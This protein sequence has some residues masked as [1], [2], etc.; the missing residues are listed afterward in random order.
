M[1]SFNFIAPVAGVLLAAWLLDEVITVSVV[2]GVALV[3][4]GLL[5]IARK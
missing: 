3:A 4:V 1:L 5:L 2:A